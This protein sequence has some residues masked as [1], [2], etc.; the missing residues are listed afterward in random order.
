MTVGRHAQLGAG[1][2]WNCDVCGVLWPRRQLKENGDGFLVCPDD[3]G[4]RT[5]TELSRIDAEE[6]AR[7]PVLR[8]EGR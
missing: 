3:Q 1:R 7:M 4:G 5:A 2:N 8:G 6:T